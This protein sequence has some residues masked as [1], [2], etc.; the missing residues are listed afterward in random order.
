[1]IAATLSTAE[2]VAMKQKFLLRPNKRAGKQG[3]DHAKNDNNHNNC[4]YLV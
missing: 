1:M 2:L 4:H 3:A